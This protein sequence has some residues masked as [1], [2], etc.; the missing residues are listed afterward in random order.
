MDE[1]HVAPW[2]GSCAVAGTHAVERPAQADDR[3][4]VGQATQR[5]LPLECTTVLDDAALQLR[6]LRVG[7]ALQNLW[8]SRDVLL[9]EPAPIDD[10]SGLGRMAVNH[11]HWSVCPVVAPRLEAQPAVE[12]YYRSA[13]QNVATRASQMMMLV[14]GTLKNAVVHEVCKPASEASD[15]LCVPLAPHL[16]TVSSRKELCVFPGAL[17]SKNHHR[18]RILF[19]WQASFTRPVVRANQD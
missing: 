3:G 5:R 16:I 4:V 7:K 1:P 10:N 12:L 14:E 9:C 11:D 19:A 8:K 6:H 2:I 18:G 13:T 15:H 17:T